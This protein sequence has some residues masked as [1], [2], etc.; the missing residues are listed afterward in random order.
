M[1]TTDIVLL[2]ELNPPML[3]QPA[4]DSENWLSGAD[5]PIRL[6][7]PARGGGGGTWRWSKLILVGNTEH[8]QLG[9]ES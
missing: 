4:E 1:L 8:W 5:A 9:H 7:P 2:C 6:V 3:K